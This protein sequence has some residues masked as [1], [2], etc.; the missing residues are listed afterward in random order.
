[1]GCSTVTLLFYHGGYISKGPQKMHVGG[2]VTPLDIDPDL[3]SYIDLRAVVKEL[4]SDICEMYQKG[5]HQ[6]MDDRLVGLTSDQ[7]MLDM[8]AMHKNSK[9][10]DIYIH[11]PMLVENKTS[12][13]KV[14]ALTRA[15]PTVQGDDLVYLDDLVDF[16]DKVDLDKIP[17]DEGVIPADP[18]EDD[19]DDDFDRDWECGDESDDD[20]FS[21]FHESSEDDEEVEQM[22]AIK[23][24]N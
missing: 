1:M 17:A 22:F 23:I 19:E 20:N 24:R 12:G 9:V 14:S 16:D 3:M 10:I 2:N 13:E 5:P 6:T 18:L 15:D 7:S 11:N 21:G 8:L 4:D